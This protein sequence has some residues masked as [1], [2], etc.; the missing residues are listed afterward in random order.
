VLVG[1]DIDGLAE[2]QFQMQRP[3]IQDSVIKAHPD[4]NTPVIGFVAADTEKAVQVGTKC[5][6]KHLAELHLIIDKGDD[7]GIQVKFLHPFILTSRIS[8][9]SVGLQ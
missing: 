4:S 7:L 2:A 5:W 3:G 8:N 9:G 6:C 1:E